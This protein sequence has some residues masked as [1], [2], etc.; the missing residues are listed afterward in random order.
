MQD[1]IS[2]IVV[3][4]EVSGLPA[5]TVAESRALADLAE[6]YQLLVELSP[7][8]IVVHEGGR[9]VYINPAG[10]RFSRAPSRAYVIGRPITDFVAPETIP[11]M[12]QRLVK[13][14]SPGSATEPADAVML[15]ADGETVVMEVVSVRTVWEGRPAFQVIM[16]DKSVQKAAEE[17]VRSKAALV[18]N[19]SDAIIAVSGDGL[20]QSWNPAAER[21]YGRSGAEAEGRA[22]GELVGATLDPAAIVAQGG[23]IETTH[24]RA[25]GAAVEVRVSAAEMAGGYV[26]V[27]ADETIRRRAEQRFGTVVA[28]MHEGVVVVDGNGVVES[29]NPAAVRMF[30]GAI[31]GIA[32]TRLALC[33]S[34][35]HAVAEGEQPIAK[36]LA[37]GESVT[38]QI[39]RLDPG[40]RNLWLSVSC[41]QLDPGETHSAVVMSFADITEQTIAGERLRYDATHDALTGL[42]NRATI[43][44]LLDAVLAEKDRTALIAVHFIDV[45]RFKIINDSLGHSTGDE[46]LRIAGD[47]LR[48]SV[49]LDDVVGRLGGDEFVVVTTSARNHD[50]IRAQ[51]ER[52]RR[53][54]SEPITLLGGQQLNVDASIGIVAAAPDDTR[55]SADLLRDADIAMYQAKTSGRARCV[56]F[57]VE[58]RE[59]LQRKLQLEQDLRAAPDLGQLSVA[60]QPIVELRTNETVG[61]EALARWLH[62]VLGTVPPVEFIPLA[63][64]SDL[65]NTI[66]AYVMSEATREVA[67]R[68]R[69]DGRQLQLAVNISARQ[70]DDPGLVEHVRDALAVSGFPAQSLCVEITESTLM[71]DPEATG[72][73]LDALRRLGV[74]LA[75][76]DFGTGYSSLAQ[77][78]RLPLDILKIGQPFVAELGSSTDA[79]AIVTSIIA[80]GHATGLTVVA[81]GVETPEQLDVL[82]RLGCDQAQ[83]Y[84]LGRPG[85]ADDLTV[86]VSPDP[87][88]AVDVR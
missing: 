18:E 76:D 69:V 34:E 55:A 9:I 75:I 13:L 57:S 86:E 52:L 19:V 15:R 74:R 29:A 85:H 16:R 59:K 62:P 40:G 35:G 56:F 24:Y 88:R 2:P 17:A 72:R 78:Q 42:A 26:L 22:V 8:A 12:V 82:A 36:T 50:G 21:V 5:G 68:R 28:S 53:T 80:M 65:I 77:L 83:G 51:A 41:R 61:V 73:T 39:L 60:Y 47:R 44:S 43:V 32:V 10:V 48:R 7:D 64:Q 6:R 25:D 49:R 20:V 71:N 27:C 30:G 66:G 14:T 87:V 67:G 3:P 4:A 45:D 54:M 46:V 70:T 58:L 81:E 84:F 11:D 31:V 79:E 38:R 33:D 63:E 1:H 23:V 37:T